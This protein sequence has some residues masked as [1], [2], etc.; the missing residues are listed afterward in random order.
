M[1]DG[2]KLK[3]SDSSLK[4]YLK[5]EKPRINKYIYNYKEWNKI[6]H[7]HLKYLKD[8]FLVHNSNY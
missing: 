3:R 6:R 1:L 7:E 8:C 4:K 5:K 2:L